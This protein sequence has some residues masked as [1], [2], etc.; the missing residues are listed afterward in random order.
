MSRRIL[1]IDTATT[2]CSVALFADDQLV[3]SAFEE[4]GRGHAEKLVPMI[5][6]L[7]DK[8]AADEIIVNG[9]PGSFTGIRIGLSAGKALA[10]AWDAS[11]SAY[12]CLHLVAA[13][14]RRSIGT[15]QPV[16]VTMSGGHGEYFVQ[17][18]DGAGNS[19][20]ELQSLAPT[21]ALQNA[22]SALLAGSGAETLA[23][24]SENCSALPILPD[25]A[26]VL[27]LPEQQRSLAPQPIY[28]R[29]PD[30]QI[31]QKT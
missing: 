25:A 3:A 8:G 19:V 15:D 2:A 5:A 18:F 29:V 14:A 4:I 21:D 1:A 28:G 22:K 31:K 30:A 9:G 26:K 6:R 12:Q 27:L 24:L 23:A 11:V 17:N 16:C 7:P 13:Q 10:L 20:D